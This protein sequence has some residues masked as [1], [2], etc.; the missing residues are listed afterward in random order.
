MLNT[1]LPSLA[2]SQALLTPAKGDQSVGILNNLFGIPGGNWHSIY[3][4]MIGGVGSG[5]LFFTLLKD[6]DLVVLAFVTIMTFITLGIGATSTAHEGK[7]FGSR[8]HALWTPLRSA[9]AMI[10]L[11]PIPGVGL[12]LIQGV[13][14]LMVWFSI[15]GANYLATAATRYMAQNGGQLTSIAPGG[16]QM[17]AKETLQSE[18]AMSFFVNY[19]GATINPI[20]TVSPWHPDGTGGAGH[21][22]VTF[23]TPGKMG[24]FMGF[25]QRGIGPG[26]AGRF[27]VKCISKKDPMCAA[28]V[29]AIV[30]MI[31]T[32]VPYAVKMVNS[33]QAAAGSTTIS[34]NNKYATQ[35]PSAQAALVVYK[36]G[37]TYDATVDAAEQQIISQAH[38]ELMQA[39]DNINANVTHLGW[40]TLGMYYW[41]IAHVNAGIQAK[42]G[43][44]PVWS[45]FDLHAIDKAMSSRTDQQTFAK[46]ASAAG[47]SVRAAKESNG[48]D[49]A[50]SLLTRVFTSQGAWF[51]NL[52]PWHLL[53][54]DPL[55]RFQMAGDLIVTTE[56]P[57][58]IA[59]YMTMR[60][61]AS[62]A[63][64]ESKGAGIFGE[65]TSWLT[66]AANAAIKTAGPYVAIAA[67][68]LFCLGA[69]WAYYLPSVPFILWTMALIG[70]LIF[71][72]EA[73]VGSVVWAAG[74]AL[75][76]GE[77]IFGPRGDQGVMLF[78]NVMFRPTL[79]VIGFFCSFMLLNTLGP[80]VGGSF[81]A[82][83]G[84]MYSI[85][86]SGVTSSSAMSTVMALNPFTYVATAA[87]TTII[88]LILVHKVFGLITWLPEN[89]FRW[90]GGQG[91][92]LG[93]SHD[94]QKARGH[95]DAIG[96]FVNKTAA[97]Q[98]AKGARGG[99]G[100]R[101]G[102]GAAVAADAGEEGDE[103]AV[104]GEGGGNDVA[105][106]GE[107]GDV[108][109]PS[110]PE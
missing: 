24:G 97:P 4:Q 56:V 14:L 79:M 6:F 96:A 86:G 1:T 93:E 18:L 45:G 7:A 63:N 55:A 70:W 99:V 110:K 42:I 72:I 95:V 31:K 51:S 106:G 38:P 54:G 84:G 60:S 49:T 10:L 39:M 76:E 47:A 48:V 3:Y 59:S 12:S 100:G 103:E 15:G 52:S 94:E 61:I 11:A 85:T 35:P 67:V 75:P 73:L 107:I 78:L 25:F 65:G 92:Q 66:G 50:R 16:G 37:K 57:G 108:A 32:E 68:A 46:I 58:A 26:Q 82:F 91:V 69:V 8:Y 71:L 9:L 90:V 13:L 98:K 23:T 44:P 64:T 89:V 41:D 104:G 43:R 83:M 74:I 101:K 109:P 30:Q 62:G 20:Y 33:T 5:S 36:A 40:W 77:G 34:Q 22:T 80:I 81:G 29:A 53:D 19:E 87:L 88:M 17:L 21:Y 28:Q 27:T 2:Q 105:G 102:L